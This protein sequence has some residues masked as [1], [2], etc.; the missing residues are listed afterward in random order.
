MAERDK[1]YYQRNRERICA[2]ERAV[3]PSKRDRARHNSLRRYYG[4]S[5]EYYNQ[6]LDAQGGVCLICGD[7]PRQRGRKFHLEVDHDHVTGQVRGL[8]C[9]KCNTALGGMRDD[10]K[11]LR[12]AIFYLEAFRGRVSNI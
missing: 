2:R 11:L 5:L 8:L 3:W 12:K 10:V 1:I 6:I 9:N 4:I 7:P